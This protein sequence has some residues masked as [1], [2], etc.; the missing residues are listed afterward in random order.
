MEISRDTERLLGNIR[1]V[2]LMGK[3]E[4]DAC[5][6]AKLVVEDS[7]IKSRTIKLGE[8]RVYL[9][10]S[11][12]NVIFRVPQNLNIGVG[13]VGMSLYWIRGQS[14]D[15]RSR[16]T[17]RGLKGITIGV[18]TWYTDQYGRPVEFSAFLEGVNDIVR[19]P[20]SEQWAFFKS[21]FPGVTFQ[22][23]PDKL[24]REELDKLAE[25]KIIPHVPVKLE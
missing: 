17:R 16:E 14:F 22:E 4:R 10:G 8:S 2:A 18:M 19:L 12:Y 13:E 15:A 11:D 23:F 21:L 24:K 5:P 7:G 1:S 25:Q 9:G 3:G 20:R 6:L